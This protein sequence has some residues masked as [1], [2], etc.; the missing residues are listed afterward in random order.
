ME[1]TEN[2]EPWEF[3]PNMETEKLQFNKTEEEVEEI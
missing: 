1:N 2:R 3:I